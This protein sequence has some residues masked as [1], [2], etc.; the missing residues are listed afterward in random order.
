[1]LGQIIVMLSLKTTDYV[2]D[3]LE[4]TLNSVPEDGCQNTEVLTKLAV[5]LLILYY[6][7][8]LIVLLYLM[9][10]LIKWINCLKYISAK[11]YVFAYK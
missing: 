4:Q 2:Q 1:M 5:V 9:F 8:V 6:I 10:G 3:T 11:R 7:P